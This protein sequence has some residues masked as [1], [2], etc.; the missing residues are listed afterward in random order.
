MKRHLNDFWNFVDLLSYILLMVALI[1]RH[2][3][4][5]ET[6]V[7]ARNLFA[8]S[9]LVTYLRFLEVFLIFR[10]VG[11]KL[12]MIKE[13]VLFCITYTS[14]E[15]NGKCIPTS[16]MNIYPFQLKDL[17][18]FLIIAVFVILGVGIYY[19]A[20]LWP[21]HR[22]MLNGGFSNWRIWKIIYYPYWQLYGEFNLDVLDGNVN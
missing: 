17:L 22:A 16:K 3:Y 18:I 4:E 9:L 8:F 20:N 21:D 5:D 1:V 11:P 10:V 6:H 14:L 15:D 19:H 7:T 13:M 12:M 2:S